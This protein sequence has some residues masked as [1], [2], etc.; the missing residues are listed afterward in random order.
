MR[1]EGECV[2]CGGCC[3]E[4]RITGILSHVLGQHGSL[5]EAR[6]YYSY[7][8][9]KIADVSPETDTLCFE[10]DTPCD[11]LTADNHCLLHDRPEIKP[12]IC[13]RY[14]V[15]PDNIKSCGY[16]FR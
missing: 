12:M 6:A 2:R 14:P 11:K 13:H 15:V 3:K 16:S 4:L 5:D 8:K 10:L 1:R 9:I 7:R